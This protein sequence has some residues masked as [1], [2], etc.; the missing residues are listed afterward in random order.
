MNSLL[1]RPKA[2]DINAGLLVALIG[3]PQ[4][5][6]YAMLSGLPPMYGLVTAAVPGLLAALLGRSA[7]VTVGPTNTTGLIILASLAPWAANSSELLTAT[8]TLACLAGIMRLLIVLLRAERIFDFVPEA[9]MVGF[10]TGAAFIIALMQ[11]DELFGTPFAGVRN[12]INELNLLLHFDLTTFSLASFT[13]GIIALL[14]VILG[15]KFFPKVPIPLAVLILSIVIVQF[16]LLPLAQHWVTL[17]QSTAVSEGWPVI[18]HHL[19]SWDMIR[20][21]II[22]SFAVAFIGSLELIVTLKYR[23]ESHLLAPELRSQGIANIAGSLTGAF[24]ASTSLTRS[25]LLDIG[26][27]KS[28]WAPLIAALAMFP[29]ILFGAPAIRSIPQPVI[30]GLLI[31]TA[32]SMI[33]PAAIR[34]MLRVNHQ[35][36]TLFLVTVFSTLILDFHEAILLGAALGIVLFLFQASQTSIRTY[37]LDAQQRLQPATEIRQETSLFVQV[38]GSLYFAAARQ[39]P[40]RL[41]QLLTPKLRYLILDLSHTHHCRV[42]AV[43]AL[44]QFTEQCSL[45]DIRIEITG[46]NDE[47]QAMTQ[48]MGVRL[49]CTSTKVIM[50]WPGE[51]VSSSQHPVQ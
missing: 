28:Q 48:K 45:R 6:A 9:V 47:L 19:P 49:P 11:I 35:T 44:L 37:R 4:C 50:I 18:N 23:A 15:K 13:L 25:V 39:L 51:A 5:L 14:S 24:P 29:I 7:A 20:A 12:V 10:A 43:Q 38:S 8:A 34:Q 36:R 32:L 33:K 31:A 30:A 41:D 26:G 40:G 46:V 42:A 3:I 22:P 27:A 2:S 16:N 21:L 17:G 1:S